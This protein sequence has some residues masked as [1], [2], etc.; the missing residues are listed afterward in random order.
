MSLEAENGALLG[1]EGALVAKLGT[2]RATLRQAARLL[3]REGLLK[4]Q[5]G[6]RGGYFAARPGV[7]TFEH[8]VGTYLETH[9][10]DPEDITAVTSVL[11]IEV[12]RRAAGMRTEEA[13]ALAEHFCTKV[14]AL[15]P[16]ASWDDVLE[17]TMDFRRAI[18]ELV[19]S[20]Y[21][22]LI[23]N[24]NVASTYQK[25]L[26]NSADSC[27]TSTHREFVRAWRRA[28][29]VELQAIS[30][31]DPEL[32]VIAARRARAIWHRRVWGHDYS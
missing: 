15:R 32:A 20:R 11:W 27:D 5:R 4:V 14:E 31:G 30:A 18:V 26:P 3:E 13:K 7:N 12:M 29:L 9:D 19:K 23:L 25:A 6:I 24:I 8:A 22:E 28:M 10:V 21:I 2:C 17:I 16:D 1:G